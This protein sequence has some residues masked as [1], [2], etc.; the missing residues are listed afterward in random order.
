MKRKIR[1]NSANEVVGVAQFALCTFTARIIMRNNVNN[2]NKIPFGH[3]ERR[4]APQPVVPLQ[5]W[6]QE[7]L[8]PERMKTARKRRHD[9]TTRRM[10]TYITLPVRNGAGLIAIT[11][12][13]PHHDS[14]YVQLCNQQ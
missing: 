5:A 12:P 2:Y 1:N 10:T 11:N 8:I 7:Q 9:V 13:T 6:M 14:T 4:S 3:F